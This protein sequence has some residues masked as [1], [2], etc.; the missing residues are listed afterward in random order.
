MA[1]MT[2]K[3]ELIAFGEAKMISNDVVKKEKGV[4]VRIHKVFMNPGVYPRM[5]KVER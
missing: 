4:C 3:D 2:L 1:I 5:Q